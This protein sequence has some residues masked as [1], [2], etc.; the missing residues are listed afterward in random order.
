MS[1]TPMKAIVENAG[2]NY[3]KKKAVYEQ[4][5]RDTDAARKKQNDAGAEMNAAAAGIREAIAESMN[6]PEDTL[7]LPF[8]KVVIEVKKGYSS[9]GGI[10]THR[11]ED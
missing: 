7:W 10:F 8:G 3:L 1:G 9:F 11:L 4:A 2:N 6:K 5:C